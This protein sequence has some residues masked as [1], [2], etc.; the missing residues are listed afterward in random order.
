MWGIPVPEARARLARGEASFLRGVEAAALPEAFRLG[1]GGPYYLSFWAEQLGDHAQARA[2][3]ALQWE[4][5]GGWW[6][7]EAG[8][9][10]LAELAARGEWAETERQARRF[11]PALRSP[12]LRKRCERALA[13]ALYWQRKDA[14][15]LS[16]LDRPDRLPADDELGLFRAA[17]SCRLAAPDWPDLFR[18]LFFRLQASSLHSRAF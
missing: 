14:E 13:E 3:L 4:R 15:L 12:E 8:L 9:G 10:L 16:R 2:L 6:K 18:D 1:P 5:G 17:S 11:L 7:E